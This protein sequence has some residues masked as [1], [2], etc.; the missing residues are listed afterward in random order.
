[1]S[2]PLNDLLTEL[3]SGLQPLYGAQ[4]KGVCLYGSYARR[5]QHSGSDVDILII[6]VDGRNSSSLEKT[7]ERSLNEMFRANN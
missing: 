4:M 5:E 1:M 3:K 2:V 6:L 7:P